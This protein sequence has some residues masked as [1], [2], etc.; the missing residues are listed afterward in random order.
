MRPT[1]VY[2]T[3]VARVPALGRLVAAATSG[4]GRLVVGVALT[5]VFLPELLAVAGV[6][7]RR[8]FRRSPA[9]RASGRVEW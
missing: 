6:R 1:Q 5:V 9:R 3:V 7:R 4:P 8:D 2:G